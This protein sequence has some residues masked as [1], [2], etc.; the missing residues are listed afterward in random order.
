MHLSKIM[1]PTWNYYFGSFPEI[2]SQ[3]SNRIITHLIYLTNVA[4]TFQNMVPKIIFI[5]IINIHAWWDLWTRWS[6]SLEPRIDIPYL[7]SSI[8]N[9]CIYPL[10]PIHMDR[11]R[12]RCKFIL[13]ASLWEPFMSN[14]LQHL[15]KWQPL[16]LCYIKKRI[17]LL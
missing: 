17:M 6:N 3:I 11:P 7:Y 5:S 2:S 8:F 13:I 10:G 12:V 1:S 9:E 16:N 14:P 4:D 15:L